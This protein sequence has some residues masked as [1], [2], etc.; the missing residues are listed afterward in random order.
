MPQR[1]DIDVLA[2]P[3][4]LWSHLVLLGVSY[5]PFRLYYR[6]VGS[7]VADMVGADWTGRYLDEVTVATPSVAAQNMET[8]KRA[9]PTMHVYNFCR[10]DPEIDEIRE[11]RFERVLFPLSEDGERVTHLI[12]TVSPRVALDQ[13]E[14]M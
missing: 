1:A 10:A 7:A 14:R 6:V 3:P 13:S 4:K 9:Q 12:G 2:L 11:L 5:D 8:I